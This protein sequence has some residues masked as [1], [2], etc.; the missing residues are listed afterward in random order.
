ML[1]RNTIGVLLHDTDAPLTLYLRRAQRLP[2]SDPDRVT[3]V[4]GDVCELTRAA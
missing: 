4:E 2:N 1:A 3:V